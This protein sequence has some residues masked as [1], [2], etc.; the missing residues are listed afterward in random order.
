MI[1]WDLNPGRRGGTLP[2]HSALGQIVAALQ[3]AGYLK[4]CAVTDSGVPTIFQSPA[5]GR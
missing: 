4:D 3:A 5:P 1:H 2:L